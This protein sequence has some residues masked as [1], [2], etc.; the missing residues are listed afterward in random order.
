MKKTNIFSVIAIAAL[1]LAACQ[2]EVSPVDETAGK[3]IELNATI[4][5]TKT[6]FDPSTFKVSWVDGDVITAT[7]TGWTA[8]FTYDATKETFFTTDAIPEG[9]QTNVAFQYGETSTADQ[10]MDCDKPLEHIAKMDKLTGTASFD[11]SVDSAINVTLAHADALMAVTVKNATA[12]PLTI[13][14]LIF[15]MAAYGYATGGKTVTLNVA[16]CAPIAVGASYTLYFLKSA[17]SNT[18]YNVTLTVVDDKG[19]EYS[20]NTNRDWQIVAGTYNT[21]SYT[22]KDIKTKTL[23]F[24]LTGKSSTFSPLEPRTYNLTAAEDGKSY[25][26]SLYWESDSKT[27]VGSPAYS[28]Y[29]ALNLS[30]YLGTPAIEGAALRSFTFT[31]AASTSTARKSAMTTHTHPGAVTKDDYD[32]SVEA[33]GASFVTG[34]KGTDYTFTIKESV[35]K[36]NTS[37]YLAC[38]NKG[39]GISKIVLV[40]EID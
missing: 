33:P 34:T 35:K 18:N 26:F 2:K 11:L 20:K 40:Y 12:A 25:P 21:T 37:Y 15:N 39:I 30:N 29:L 19:K 23:T 28:S 14:K 16:N 9:A 1:S 22:V 32:A 17:M 31:Q 27:N 4:E 13:A 5:Q 7:G 36:P 24:D 38:G 3:V 10:N 8:K 6:T